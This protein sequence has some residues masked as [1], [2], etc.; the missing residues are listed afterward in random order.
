[1]VI[2]LLLP[3]SLSAGAGCTLVHYA[4][5]KDIF[6]MK[7]A[8]FCSDKLPFF[9]YYDSFQFGLNKLCL[10][11]CWLRGGRVLTHLIDRLK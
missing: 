4:F 7:L 3:A 9:L 1:M 10:H 6:M 11:F 8:Q 5:C 2:P